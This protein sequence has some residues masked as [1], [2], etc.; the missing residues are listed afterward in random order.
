MSN[1]QAT[2]RGDRAFQFMALSTLPAADRPAENRR[3]ALI[4]A[5]ATAWWALTFSTAGAQCDSH[6]CNS[7]GGRATFM[8]QGDCANGNCSIANMPQSLQMASASRS[9]RDLNF[10]RKYIPDAEIAANP[11]VYIYDESTEPK[12][13]QI[14]YDHPFPGFHLAAYNMSWGGNAHTNGDPHGN[15]N[16][17]LPWGVAGGT[18]RCKP[19][20]VAGGVVKF[21][22]M[23]L[24]EGKPVVW[25]ERPDDPRVSP[26]S[27]IYPVGTKFG[28][29]I[30]KRCKDGQLRTVEM[31]TRERLERSWTVD[32]LRP[33]PTAEHLVKAL[34]TL[35]GEDQYAGAT[36]LL[37]HVSRPVELPES[38]MFDQHQRQRAFDTRAAHDVLPDLDAKTE[39]ALLDNFEFTSALGETWRGDNCFAPEGG[40]YPDNYDATHLGTTD[41]SCL[42]CHRDVGTSVKRFARSPE[43]D[44]YGNIRG[45]DGIFSKSWNHPSCVSPNGAPRR[46]VMLHQPGI[47]ERYDPSRHVGYHPLEANE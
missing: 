27:W 14:A 23:L 45:G 17:E 31:R 26:V 24:P 20:N 22:W 29:V 11:R 33:F 15:G 47:I 36:A 12:V 13:Y 40:V 3:L 32:I 30:L 37:H 5:I 19:G 9:P 1:L 4:A 44:W 25:Y 21:T 10:L 2:C 28:E 39:A 35:Q 38:R 16:H 7:S 46:I 43:R 42:R 8:Q 6:G 41:A 34:Q 18:H